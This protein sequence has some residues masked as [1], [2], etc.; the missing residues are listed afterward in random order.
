L[1]GFKVTGFFDCDNLLF[2]TFARNWT[3]KDTAAMKFGVDVEGNVGIASWKVTPYYNVYADTAAVA[4]E[5]SV[6]Y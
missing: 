1:D 3:A 5:T 4:F 2:K 6:N